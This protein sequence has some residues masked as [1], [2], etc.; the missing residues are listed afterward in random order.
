[1]DTTFNVI[2]LVVAFLLYIFY[3][4]I[5]TYLI[6]NF[7]T[8]SSN[9][10]WRK[11]LQKNKREEES[12]TNYKTARRNLMEAIKDRAEADPNFDR[13]WLRIGELSKRHNSLLVQEI[14]S[15][16]YEISVDGVNWLLEKKVKNDN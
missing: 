2:L 12:E 10:Y 15:A 13:F 11:K 6:F 7:G 16:G 4:E 14:S 9:I 1:M 5:V 3:K 8:M